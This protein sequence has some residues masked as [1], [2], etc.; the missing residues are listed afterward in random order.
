L[1]SKLLSKRG[2]RADLVSNG[3]QAVAAVQATFYDLIL[4]DMQM[5]VMDG[6]EATRAIRARAGNATPIVAMTANAFAEERAACLA[7]GM[8]DH[9]AKPV[10][11]EQLYATLLRW[12]RWR[13]TAQR[14]GADSS[15]LDAPARLPLVDRLA[16]V[17]DYDLAIGLHNVGGAMPSLMKVLR[18]FVDTYRVGEPGLLDV[19]VAGSI[20]RWSSI[21]HE[22]RG[23]CSAIGA[24]A[25][26]FDFQELERRIAEGASASQC[27][28]RAAQL[29]E[30][31]MVLAGR[32]AVAIET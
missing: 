32:L 10:D 19:V 20:K 18:R 26:T 6:L 21:C 13:S 30:D 5:P 24:T 31:L 12:L 25:L 27:A 29:N 23:A 22:L 28:H 11:P 3:V 7:A 16:A 14:S 17:E 1:I 8:N 4:M 2:Y 9:L 15:P